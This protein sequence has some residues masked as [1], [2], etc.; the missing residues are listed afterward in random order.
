MET[1]MR[2]LLTFLIALAAI[3]VAVVSPAPSMAW[4]QSVQQVAVSS[5]VTPATFTA[6]AGFAGDEQAIAFGSNT[7]NSPSITFPPGTIIIFVAAN[8]SGR[9]A[10]V[11]S[12]IIGGV[13]A[14]PIAGATNASQGVWYANSV[15]A[16]TVNPGIVINN[17]VAWADIAVTGGLITS[18]SSTPAG[19]VGAPTVLQNPSHNTA[20]TFT[21]LTVP[22]N[23]VGVAG[24]SAAIGS[25]ALPLTWTGAASSSSIAEFQANSF[26][27]GINESS[28]AG[29]FNPTESS[30]GSAWNFAQPT[31]SLVAWG[32]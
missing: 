25:G 2:K 21:S 24:I 26:G 18:T 15:P 19:G 22:A 7:Y 12:V 13:T 28:G 8:G 17:S 20:D 4:W 5:G 32:P 30:N 14:T 3:V 29:T 9:I 16:G 11:T 27:I 10:G 1:K 23:G 31:G 6:I